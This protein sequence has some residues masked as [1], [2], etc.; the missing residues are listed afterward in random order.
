MAVFEH[1]L[2]VL[3]LILFFGLM[4]PDMF[5]RL[6][7]PFVTTLIILG[8]GFGPHGL[9]YIEANDT[10]S[11]FGFLGSAFIMFM[12]GLEISKA[13]LINIRKH[14]YALALID[15]LVPFAAGLALTSFLGYGPDAA[16][17]MGVLYVSSAL[18]VIVT[19]VK[20]THF[21]NQS[22]GNLI[23]GISIIKDV[24]SLVLLSV[25]LQSITPI[26][27]FPLPIYI[28]VLF[29]SIWVLK[30]FIPELTAFFLKSHKH[31]EGHM[32]F[33]LVVLIALMLYFDT[34]GVHPL[35]GAFIVGILFSDSLKSETISKKLHT[36]GY[37]IFVPV[38]FVIAGMELDISS[39]INISNLA[40][41]LIVFSIIVVKFSCGYLSA[42]LQGF[43]A[44]DSM[45]VGTG[46]TMQLTTTLAIGFTAADLGIIDGTLVSSVVI[47]SLLTT[48]TVPPLLGY[49]AK[50]KHD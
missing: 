4:L 2:V 13:Q 36:I 41:P 26:T 17:M 33:I 21:R 28:G 37:G 46:S 31:N 7:L 12:A 14:I 9:G 45:S 50:V 22:A 16:F 30:I 8:A 10:I 44:W 47:S 43:K 48:V 1:T 49:L 35:V 40:I 42:R 34:L 19:A 25:A 18:A 32:R 15:V 29:C 11:F 23:I 38:F 3:L 39:I 27:S 20:S 5:K 6:R 24:A